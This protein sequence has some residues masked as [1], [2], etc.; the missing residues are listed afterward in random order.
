MRFFNI[1]V[2]KI[3]HSLHPLEMVLYVSFD[4]KIFDV[5]FI[6]FMSVAWVSYGLMIVPLLISL[7]QFPFTDSQSGHWQNTTNLPIVE[8]WGIPQHSFQD[9]AAGDGALYD[10][11][12][13]NTAPSVAFPVP[14]VAGPAQIDAAQGGIHGG[15]EGGVFGDDVHGGAGGGGVGGAEAGVVDAA[16]QNDPAETDLEGL[17]QHFLNAAAQEG[18]EGWMAEL[19]PIIEKYRDN[20]LAGLPPDAILGDIRRFLLANPLS[21]YRAYRF[22][23]KFL[24][25]DPRYSALI[26][27]ALPQP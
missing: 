12:Q 21:A 6:L 5:K 19:M 8:K 3:P 20:Q 26:L 14:A 23:S 13:H 22:I 10:V 2:N 4:L 11:T 24:K 17:L 16:V 25:S 7:A 27:N 15:A 9:G 18:N 1:K